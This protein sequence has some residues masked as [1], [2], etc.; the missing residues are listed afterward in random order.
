M[1][2]L[3]INLLILG[4]GVKKSGKE[5]A[6]QKIKSCADQG[7][8]ADW[9]RKYKTAFYLFKKAAAEGDT[10]VFTILGYYYDVGR[11][12]R[13]NSGLAMY[14]YKRAVKCNSSAAM[15]NLGTIYRDAGNFKL[16]RSWF[17]RAVK[18]GDTDAA[19]ELAKTYMHH[20]RSE[21]I[22]EKWLR[23][24]LRSDDKKLFYDS[25]ERATKLLKKLYRAGNDE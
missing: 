8:E 20:G 1:L 17:K 7:F 4:F 19:I 12:V 15:N 25:K 10:I 16:A 21:K 6:K 23:F 11:G 13:K 2:D 22:A 9:A 5:I 3:H 14:W 18:R 24:V